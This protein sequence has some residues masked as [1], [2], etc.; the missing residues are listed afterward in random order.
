MNSGKNAMSKS[1]FKKKRM[2]NNKKNHEYRIYRDKLNSLQNE[3][4]MIELG[5]Q[6]KSLL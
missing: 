2:T 3:I 1:I 4:M 5:K 6:Y